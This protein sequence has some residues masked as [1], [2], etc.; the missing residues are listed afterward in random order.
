MK[1]DL[2][3][4][5][6]T[7]EQRWL[8]SV[9]ISLIIFKA[10]YLHMISALS[11]NTSL[12]ETRS[13]VNSSCSPSYTD[14]LLV[15]GAF[16]CAVHPFT[17][18]W[19]TALILACNLPERVKEHSNPCHPVLISRCQHTCGYHKTNTK[20]SPLNLPGQL[21]SLDSQLPQPRHSH[22]IPVWIFRLVMTRVMFRN[23]VLTWT[24]VQMFW[25]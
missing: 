9:E 14:Y 19:G 10:S 7:Y 18:T 17:E 23:T 16:S 5:C 22:V 25:S 2:R 12:R 20:W 6:P 15:N 3:E 24:A 1:S 4:T 11:A 21:A 8:P 13:S